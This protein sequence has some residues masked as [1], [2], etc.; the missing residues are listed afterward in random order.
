[1]IDGYVRYP[2]ALKIM[3]CN[4][5]EDLAWAHSN[6]PTI[7]GPW[8]DVPSKQVYYVGIDARGQWTRIEHWPGLWRH[9]PELVLLSGRNGTLHHVEPSGPTVV[10]IELAPSMPGIMARRPEGRQPMQ[11]DGLIDGQDFYF[12]EDNGFWSLSVG[13]SDVINAPDWHHEDQHDIDGWISE[14]QAYALLAA[15]A[16]LFRR[17]GAEQE[18][19]N[20]EQE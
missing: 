6:I 19:D 5:Q 12:R 18:Q 8:G 13:G 15:G 1:M 4:R 20:G 9:E 3:E 10:R 11:M 2:V 7:E 17:R 16:A 14:D